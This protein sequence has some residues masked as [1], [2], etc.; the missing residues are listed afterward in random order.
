MDINDKEKYSCESCINHSLP[1]SSPTCMLCLSNLNT[2]G[3]KSEYMPYTWTVQTGIAIVPPEAD[4]QC[5]IIDG[6]REEFKKKKIEEMLNTSFLTPNELRRMLGLEEV[7]DNSQT[8]KA[9]AGKLDL[10]LVPLQIIEDIAEVREYGNKKYHDPDNWKTVDKQR[11]RA[12][13]FRHLIAYL[14]DPD[15]VDEE[16][17]I[18]HYKHMACNMAFLCEMEKEEKDVSSETE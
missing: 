8:A 9:D 17:G 2:R 18:K 7:K 1:G 10:T 16:S 6:L 5:C 11:Y 13:L 4:T 3:V 12:A 14:R 15:G